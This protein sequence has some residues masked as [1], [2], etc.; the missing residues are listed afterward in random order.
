MNEFNYHSGS[1][2]EFVGE[3]P[4]AENA[5]VR[6][7]SLVAAPMGLRRIRFVTD[8]FAPNHVVTIRGSADGWTADTFGT[9]RNGAWDFFFEIPS[10]PATMSF[11]FVLDG[12]H[13]MLGADLTVATNIDHQFDESNVDF[14]V[15][16]NRFLHGYDNFWLERT[17]AAQESVPRNTQD[18]LYDVIV[19]GSGVGGGSLADA[20]SDNGVKT[21]VLEAGGLRLP[22]HM[23]NLPGDWTRVATHHA[24]GHF[25]NE[26]GSD[27]LPGV[28][29]N[30]G[31]RSV[32][33]SG[34]IP[35]MHDWELQFWPEPISDYLTSSDGYE[36]AERLLRKRSK[37]GPF[38]DQVVA[39]LGSD[40]D[41]WTVEDVP[42]SRHQPFVD[43]T[44]AVGNILESSTGVYSTADVLLSS[45]S[46][47]GRAGRQNLTINSGHLVTHLET[48]GDQVSRVVCQDLLGNQTRSYRGKYVV[49]AAG[50]LESAK[51]V[52]NSG[53]NDPN[54]KVGVG[55]TDH[56]AF[57]S[58]QYTIPGNNPFSGS[59]KHAKVFL[60]RDDATFD[61]HPFNVEVLINPA[62][63]HLRQSDTDLLPEPRPSVI[64]LKFVFASHLDDENFVQSRGIGHKLR[65]KVKRNETG[66]P[67]F[68]SARLTRNAI[69]D[70]LDVPFTAS[71]G[72]G[73]GNEGT[74]HHAGGTL[75]ASGDATGVVDT[76]LKFE[77]Y[78][79][80]YC[81]D[82]SAWPFIP[83]ANPVLTLVAL[84][85]RLAG[86]L[87]GRVGS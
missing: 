24:V 57:F 63:W 2:R 62:F 17:K 48:D 60:Y 47:P 20:L 44:G 38:Q 51:I 6:A 23:T 49:L 86:H 14:E 87:Q 58:A 22:T 21:L 30:L 53:L 9:Y 11:K 82:P 67:H 71:E 36:S 69:L 27:F 35:R 68:D 74:V 52:L 12:E 5:G 75:R 25:H 40:L 72:M 28:H 61:N 16:P 85:Q 31:G 65:V 8:R 50:S 80:L 84:T 83:A 32:Y 70:S 29:L 39:K 26:P 77:Q 7:A 56:P 3:R 45:L 4:A 10:L 81:A 13:W 1:G 15:G 41:S 54:N 43:D 34:L 79:N 78:D 46:F 64:E 42:R 59:D 55:L 66:R 37:L 76:D 73:Y 18:Q 19:I 33:W